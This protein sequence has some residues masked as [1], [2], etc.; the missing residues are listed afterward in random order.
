MTSAPEQTLPPSGIFPAPLP[1]FVSLISVLPTRPLFFL[2]VLRPARQPGV[3][4][5]RCSLPRKTSTVTFPPVPLVRRISPQGQ[6]PRPPQYF[7]LMPSSEAASPL[8]SKVHCVLFS[9]PNFIPKD[10]VFC[11]FSSFILVMTRKSA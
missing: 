2:P 1:R 5:F 11:S 9:F 7:R 4:D 3:D 6:L 8:L 10:K